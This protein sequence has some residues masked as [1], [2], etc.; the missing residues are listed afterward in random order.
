MLTKIKILLN[1]FHIKNIIL[2]LS[3]FILQVNAETKIIA[4]DG[5]T[6]LKISTKYG[7]PLKELMHKNNFSDANKIIE[8]EV[9]IIPLK[10]KNEPENDNITYKVTEGDTLYKIARNY[11]VNVN[12]LISINNL[13]KNSFL[14]PNQIILLPIGAIHREIVSQKDIKL[15]TKKVF[16]HQT[17]KKENILDIAQKHKI[18]REEIITLNKLNDQ[19]IINPNTKL[20]IRKNKP[21]KWL[22]YGSLTINWS[23][24][25]YLDGNYITQAKNKKN[26]SFYI[27]ISCEKRVLNNTLKNSFWTSW[28]FP[29]SAFEFKLINDFCDKDFKI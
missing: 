24:W 25:R 22:K 6:L 13:D 15:A 12:D 26:K 9:V 20:K 28:Y 8:G 19:K 27:A 16:Y 4:K 10:N 14:I 11:N 17:S 2:F 1:I 18:T 23:D 29:K 5:D 3:F 21:L 7:V